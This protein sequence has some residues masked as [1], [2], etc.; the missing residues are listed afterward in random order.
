MNISDIKNLVSGASYENEI[1]VLE[2]IC[3]YAGDC[4]INGYLGSSV[5][6]ISKDRKGRVEFES[7]FEGEYSTFES[8]GVVLSES[9]VIRQCQRQGEKELY[10]LYVWK[11]DGSCYTYIAVDTEDVLQ[12]LYNGLKKMD[13]QFLDGDIHQVLE[14]IGVS[15][16]DVMDIKTAQEVVQHSIDVQDIIDTYDDTIMSEIE[17]LS[18]A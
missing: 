8:T 5:L 9:V 16:N 1:E 3:E 13:C 15:L 14:E 17:I 6:S 7:C 10:Q 2:N 18:I 11:K 12:T 4:Q